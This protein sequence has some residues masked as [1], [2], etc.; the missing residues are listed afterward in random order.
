[1]EGGVEKGLKE[2]QDKLCVFVRVFVCVWGRQVVS[3]HTPPPLP[4]FFFSPFC[5]THRMHAY[6]PHTPQTRRASPDKEMMSHHK[7]HFTEM[8]VTPSV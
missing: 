1:M 2:I 3:I 7:R 5:L 8:V 6:I 4:F